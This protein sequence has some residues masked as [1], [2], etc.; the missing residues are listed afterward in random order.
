M[1]KVLGIGNALVDIL[2]QLDD[3]AVLQQFSLPKGSMQL[4]DEVTANQILNATDSFHKDIVSGGSASNTIHGLAALGIETGFIG[5][6]RRDKWGD[7]YESDMQR[8]NIKPIL[9]EGKNET[10][11]A[12]T[13]ISRPVSFLQHILELPLN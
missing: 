11:R 5:K 9:F 2:M 8:R 10:G 7:L 4:V 3:D 12:I 13:F 6:T 1:K